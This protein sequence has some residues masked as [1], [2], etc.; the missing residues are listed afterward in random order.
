MKTQ[1]AFAS[2]NRPYTITANGEDIARHG[3]I[4]TLAYKL[5]TFEEMR[6]GGGG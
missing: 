1:S 5:G 6:P 4:A 2:S 3:K